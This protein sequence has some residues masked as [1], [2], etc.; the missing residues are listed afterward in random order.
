MGY[1]EQMNKIYQALQYATK[2]EQN[3]DYLTGLINRRGF[4]EV[5]KKMPA[6]ML[7]HC[8]YIDVDNFK[9]VNDIY[10]HSRGD[11]LLVY[12]ARILNE[13][14][15]QQLVIRMGG[16]E[17]VVVCEGEIEEDSL[18]SR[19]DHLQ[20]LI[21]E[22]FDT[23]VSAL[24][25]FSMGL[26]VK[27]P[28]S[29][30]ISVILD[31]CDETMYYVKKNGK[32]SCIS[33]EEIKDHLTEQK[34]MKDRS[35]T[36]INENEIQIL[37]RPIIYM[38][39]SD[40]YAAQVVAQWDFPGLGILPEEKFF[41]VFEQYGVSTFLDEI[42]F[43]Q[44]CKWKGQWKNTVLESMMMFVRIS[45]L[46]L[47]KADAVA[48]LIQCME[49]YD[50][51]AADFKLCVDEKSF[52]IKNKMLWDSIKR[53]RDVGFDLAIQNFGS[54]AS[55]T[56]LQNT[57][58]TVLKLDQTL[59]SSCMGKDLKKE[60]I[61]RNV[62]SMGR[63]L[64]FLV[65]AQGIENARQAEML[66]NYGAQLGMGD[67]YGVAQPAEKFFRNYKDRY[68]FFENQKPTAYHFRENLLDEKGASEGVYYGK[69]LRYTNGVIDSQYAVEL[70][71]GN[72]KE[73]LIELPKTVMYT[74][75]YTICIWVNTQ[76]IQYWTSVFYVVY[77]NGFISLVPSDARGSCIFRL[78][79]DR[80]TNGWFDLFC[81]GA[82][83]GEWAY[84]CISYDVI[85]GLAKLY[86]N[87]L[88]H[89][90]RSN[91]PNL[92][93]VKQIFVGGDEYQE[94]YKGKIAGL[95]IHHRVLSEEEIR[96][97]YK[98]YQDNATF[99]GTRVVNRGSEG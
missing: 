30:G 70:P 7:V 94:S 66:S 74:E 52:L 17:F 90:T 93:H 42:V 91:A 64:R 16:D 88:L 8:I 61:L 80:E 79:D 14:F 26:T 75:S 31:Q 5:W 29:K 28:V 92:K 57:P 23:S 47:M 27:Q 56:V 59:L 48:H 81:R 54:A 43:E 44:A 18:K 13:A 35:L 84:I 24:L 97:K 46:Y 85:T 76:A 6:D 19:I 68:F 25:S 12:V 3:I 11:E 50:V 2:S 36:A 83:V 87:G 96:H 4:Y 51:S 60:K 53:L 78:K 86:F 98:E 63:D 20:C 41:P 95:E 73:N 45:G 67:F 40:V 21:K 38:Q 65:V 49:Q 37:M 33:Y 89:S 71:G 32:G 10:G 99:L 22:D 1:N 55:F 15:P 72:V 62:I 9:L 82:I 34:A 58:A 77:E 39:T 69:D